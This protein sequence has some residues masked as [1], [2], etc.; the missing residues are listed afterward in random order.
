VV[1]DEG[2]QA[3][4]SLAGDAVLTRGVERR[5]FA[6]AFALALTAASP[7]VAQQP[8]PFAVRMVELGGPLGDP[9]TEAHV[10]HSRKLGFN[11]VFVGSGVAGRWAPE[12]GRRAPSVDRAFARFA[13][14]C[15]E[16]GMDVWV[17]LNPVADT[18]GRFAF[19]DP[20][21][22]RRIA[23]FVKKLHAETGI[24]G[25]VLSFEDQPVELHE[26]Q[27]IVRFGRNAAPAHLDLMRRLA[28][29]VPPGLGLWL[30]ASTYCDAHLADGT[31]PYAK[32]YLEGLATLPPTVGVV[33][34][35]PRVICPSITGEALVATRTRLGGRRILLQDNFPA[36]FDEEN[37]ALALILGG[38][39]GR[40]AGVRDA[41]AAYL[42]V[43]MTELG[44]SR[45]ALATTAAYLADPEGYDP[46]AAVKHEVESLAGGDPEIRRALDTQQLEWGGF[47]DGLNYWPRAGLNAPKAGRQLDDPG[48]VES[49]TWTADRY[50][51]RIAVLARLADPVFRDDLLRAMRRRLVVARALP[52]V[53]EYDARKRAGRADASDALAQIH[54]ERRLA[55]SDHDAARILDLFLRAAGV[56]VS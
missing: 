20:E 47:I 25:L 31:R 53:R 49:F 15:R 55:A 45:L 24:A 9:A 35:G 4:S 46:D 41:V 39:R 1:L 51:G 3:R 10:A 19:S 7:A 6:A 23:A 43:P 30:H 48:F 28:A 8:R 37:D 12:S 16:R 36:N 11:A 52:L 22:A 56:P 40:D 26:F 32:A 54:A 42:A 33:W 50:P 27:D 17:A 38:L 18:D 34:T 13:R 14:S 21:G 29:G 2:E 44:G 5:L